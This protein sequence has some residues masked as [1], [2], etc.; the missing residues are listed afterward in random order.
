M[1]LQRQLRARPARLLSVVTGLLAVLIGS[2]ALAQAA[3]LSKVASAS[4]T[5]TRYAPDGKAVGKVPRLADGI[6]EGPYWVCTDPVPPLRFAFDLGAAR[7]VGKI[8]IANYFTAKSSS[9][10]DRAFKVVDIFVGD[11]LAPATGGAPAVA[12][13]ELPMSN[14]KGP[15]WTELVLDKP[16]KGRI[17][18]LRVQSNWGGDWYS[19]N[20]VEIY[21]QE[22]EATQIPN[23]KPTQA[24]QQLA[25][26]ANQPAPPSPQTRAIQ[27]SASVS[28]T[29]PAIQLSW[30]A[31]VSAQLP[32]KVYRK[33]RFS[34]SWGSPITTL[35][36]DATSWVDT[37]AS[38]GEAYEYMIIGSSR[39]QT[40]TWATYGFIYAGIDVPMIDSRGTLI[41]VVDN[42]H[43]PA[44]DSELARLQQDLIGD[45]WTVIRHDVSPTQTVT[46]VK[47]LIQADYK[48]DP[49]RVKSLLLFGHV[50]VPWSGNTF[51]IALEDCVGA[52]EADIF[53][54]DVD[55]VWTDTLVNHTGTAFDQ[56]RINNVPGDGRYD[57]SIIPSDTEL[58][59]GRVDL[60]KMPSF[61]QGERELLRN[62]L[63]KDH[64]YRTALLQVPRQGAIVDMEGDLN[65]GAYVVSGWRNNSAFFG[66]SNVIEDTTKKWFNP[67]RPVCMF[68]SSFFHASHTSGCFGNTANYVT[69]DPG[70]VV[71]FGGG[72][73]MGDWDYPDDILK[74]PLCSSTYGL[75]AM[76]MAEPRGY[77]HT[78]A[79]GD[80]IGAGIWLT[81]NIDGFTYPDTDRTDG[82]VRGS[83]EFV[84]H[85][86]LTYL[87]DPSLRLNPV[88]PPSNLVVN[89]SSA[90]SA[91]LSWQA[92]ADSGI[93]G[94]LVYR[95][96]GFGAFTRLT[97][98][99]V[100]QN[101]FADQGLSPG[102]YT[103][104]V[105]AVKLE[106]NGSG[107][108]F[109]P[110]EGVFQIVKVGSGGPAVAMVSPLNN[111]TFSSGT[112]VVLRANVSAAFNGSVDF[113]NGAVKLGTASAAPYLYVWSN[114]APGAYSL[115]ARASDASGATVSDPVAISVV[116]L[117]D[118]LAA[119][120]LQADIGP[121][122][123]PGA[124]TI[125]G[126]S[127]AARSFQVSGSG[128]G[129]SGGQDVCHTVYQPLNVDGT[130]T[131]RV[132]SV[133]GPGAAGLFLRDSLAADAPCAAVLVSS[134]GAVTFSSRP[135]AGASSTTSDPTSVTLPHWLR[136]KRD[137][138]TFSAYHSTD[139][140]TWSQIGTNVMIGMGST[141]DLG[142]AAFSGNANSTIS[143]VFTNVS[144]TSPLL[145]PGSYFRTPY[146]GDAF[147][148]GQSI[149]LQIEKPRSADDYFTGIQ[150]FDDGAPIAPESTGRIVTWT[151][152]RT[153]AHQVTAVIREH[154]GMT[155][156]I[157]ITI[158]INPAGAKYAT[159]DI[160]EPLS[161]EPLAAPCDLSVTA[162]VAPATGTTVSKVEF[163]SGKSLIGAVT[164]P[165][166]SVVL[167]DIQPGNRYAV[168]A[169][170]ID[171]FGTV[172]HS[173]PVFLY[174]TGGAKSAVSRMSW[175]DYTDNTG[176]G[177]LLADAVK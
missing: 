148:L 44:L 141:P 137:G 57:Q 66:A 84:R 96:R 130:I 67:L 86:Y 3:P 164:Q 23:P 125:T 14:G 111:A 155:G 29:P 150:F 78:I 73:Y 176:E 135:A 158:Y 70:V 120:W 56:A 156:S 83:D 136:L 19:A 5:V 90:S 75:G 28:R 7:T 80:T 26:A 168:S 87:G 65:G 72:C 49:D 117:P 153:G 27:V 52:T 163:Y 104:M 1:E 95:A 100:T 154:G 38:V 2:P 97:P 17:I 131:A 106:T 53:Y 12:G 174:A 34:K 8:R 169:R 30:P 54:A 138:D 124:A 167:K 63:N 102:A 13:K 92:P 170:T 48:A 22:A 77:L 105:R 171:N 114:A 74:A 113:Y 60:S 88:L 110:S 152:T 58:Q 101:T 116:K 85:V 71:S 10:A 69:T 76:F 115:T 35:T 123:A 166:Y 161:G 108:Y 103:Y 40:T 36:P 51:P 42:T 16:I 173:R 91:E 129:L 43:A 11:T 24:V 159:V 41:L 81:Q 46:S 89:A 107:T 162:S 109:N 93:R 47:A 79:L 144:A 45:G 18:T 146:D 172:T 119:P 139:G 55:G 98:S 62:Y 142:M 39:Y 6:A 149:K 32:F 64:N 147:T 145:T 20:E 165:P 175:Y 9:H 177:Q 133:G 143:A 157:P 82:P 160:T 121:T 37:Q 94:Y 21:T 112:T 127:P 31:L 140:A 59:F 15:A 50:P 33:A 126:A 99:V 151:P 122:A 128:A 4:V 68:G 132:A 118:E 134:S 61:T 25:S